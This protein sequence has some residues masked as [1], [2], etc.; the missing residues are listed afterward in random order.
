MINE[1]NI[2]KKLAEMSMQYNS[3]SRSEKADNIS[4]AS[5]SSISSWN[6]TNGDVLKKQNVPSQP[7]LMTSALQMIER[8][9]NSNFNDINTFSN[10]NNIAAASRDMDI[11]M[12]LKNLLREHNIRDGNLVETRRLDLRSSQNMPPGTKQRIYSKHT[13]ESLFE[14]IILNDDNDKD[15]KYAELVR[16]KGGKIRFLN[17]KEAMNTSDESSDSDE[18]CDSSMWIERYRKQKLAIGKK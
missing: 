7:A 4:S 11:N 1:E 5:S 6:N 8:E 3:T 2:M 9:L 17:E 16:K 10:N 18:V 13:A 15:N 14:N 12:E